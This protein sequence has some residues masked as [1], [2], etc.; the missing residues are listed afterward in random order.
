M[1]TSRRCLGPE[2]CSYISV[3]FKA[4]PVPVPF[5]SS[6][7]GMWLLMETICSGRQLGSYWEL[8]LHPTMQ[9]LLGGLGCPEQGCKGEHLTAG[10][11]GF[12][13]PVGR[14]VNMGGTLGYTIPTYSQSSGIKQCFGYTLTATSSLPAPHKFPFQAS[15]ALWARQATSPAD[16]LC[17]VM[18]APRPVEAAS[19]ALLPC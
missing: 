16:S 7:S 18:A 13:R 19:Q 10:F 6:W 9:P 1:P 2:L 11:Q 8:N 4:Y 12:I 3:Y 14:P 15:S 5:S 17:Q